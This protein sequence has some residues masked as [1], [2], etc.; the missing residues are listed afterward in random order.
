MQRWRV[1][2]NV[3]MAL[4]MDPERRAECVAERERIFKSFQGDAGQNADKTMSQMGDKSMYT[5]AQIRKRKALRNAPLVVEQLSEMWKL[6]PGEWDRTSPDASMPL[7]AYIEFNIRL[8][9]ALIAPSALLKETGTSKAERAEIARKTAL[10]D[11]EHDTQHAGGR[12]TQQTF[13]DSVFELVDVWSEGTDET[14]Y[15]ALMWRLSRAVMNGTDEEG[16]FV[17]WKRGDEIESAVQS[18]TKKLIRQFKNRS[19]IVNHNPMP[20]FNLLDMFPIQPQVEVPTKRN[21]PKPSQLYQG[22]LTGSGRVRYTQTLLPSKEQKNEPPQVGRHYQFV[23]GPHHD[24][25]AHKRPKRSDAHMFLLATLTAR[26]VASEYL[27]GHPTQG[28]WIRRSVDLAR[29]RCGWG[30]HA[31]PCERRFRRWSAPRGTS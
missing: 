29:Q 28:S 19:E 21:P 14:E 4:Q 7:E 25:D 22:V 10:A 18:E 27:V 16:A 15:A 9:K 8:Y 20:D 3:F 5:L 31:S 11:W 23:Q 6:I 30:S 2:K 24:P 26:T 12:M 1:T 13:S 17:T